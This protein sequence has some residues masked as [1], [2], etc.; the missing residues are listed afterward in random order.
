MAYDTSQPL[1][2]RLLRGVVI[3]LFAILT[4]NL[5]GLMVMRHRHYTAQALENRQVRFR[6]RAPR[7]RITDRHGRP[8]ADN[9]FV[10]DITIPASC[11]VEN[12]PDST[13]SRLITWFDLPEDTTL[14]EL[15]AQKARGRR[16]LVLVADADMQRIVAVEERR[17]QLRG[18]QVDSRLSRRYLQGALFAHVIGYVGE[19][20]QSDI[21]AASADLDYRLRD[22]IGKQGVEA[23]FESALRGMPGLKL[24]EVNASG[25]IVGR[26]SVWLQPVVPGRDVALTLSLPL[27]QEMD[28]LLAGRRGCGVAVAVPSGEVLAAVSSPSFDPNQLMG[29]LSTAEWRGLSEDPAKPFFNR[30]VQA[31]YPPGSLYK[32]ITAL[33]GLKAAVIDTGTYLDPCYGGYRFGNR[34]FRCWRAAGHGS[35]SLTGALAHS[36]DVYFYQVGLKLD[37]DTLAS[38]ARAFGLGSP[39]SGIFPEEVSGNVPTTAWYDQRYGRGGWSR[40]VLLNNAIGQGEILVTPL[41]VAMLSARLAAG[42]RVPSPTFV[43][44]QTP[45]DG[46]TTLPFTASHL[47]WCRRALRAVVDDGTGGAAQQAGVSVAGKTGTA[48][49]PHGEDHAWFMCYAPA[50]APEVAVAVVLENAGHGGSQAAPVAGAWLKYYLE[51]RD[52]VMPDLDLAGEMP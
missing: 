41:Q 13:L 26:Q 27:Q 10:A 36:C 47:A 28:R 8:L 14:A 11:L 18:V 51:H 24:E 38:A 44:G 34:T 23:A 6:V 40:G 39:C 52:E 49:N 42:G 16:R 29:S 4:V 25:R 43:Y 9:R 15:A 22:V 21:D 17:S 48:Q 35:L 30:I 20:D 33:A 2:G 3:L 50:N 1:R 7:G 37:I 45:R 19:V 46:P 31:T 32:P 5:V 12:Q